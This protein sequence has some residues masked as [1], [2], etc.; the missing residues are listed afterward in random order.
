[1]S[2]DPRRV[3]AVFREAVQH[4]DTVG[5]API[6]GCERP[7]DVR[8]RRRVEAL[9]RA[10]D[11]HD[12]FLN[13]PM[14]SFEG[15]SSGG[16]AS[17]PIEIEALID[18]LTRDDEGEAARDR[19]GPP[20]A[21]PAMPETPWR[22][23]GNR[24]ED[25]PMAPDPRRVQAVFWETAQHPDPADRAPILERECSDDAELRRRVEALLRA[26]DAYDSFLNEP[27]V[28]LEAWALM[29]LAGPDDGRAEGTA[30]G[31]AANP[32]DSTT[33][34]GGPDGSATG[35]SRGDRLEQD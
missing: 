20:V 12:T 8:L 17:R 16:A 27:I 6:L 35:T 31:P 24:R 19:A 5:R 23:D 9:P 34:R 21:R 15:R 29:A 2:L 30:A 32:D 22:D 1:M 7:D 10:H 26:H 11:T 28:S 18:V 33:P 13:E 4:P 25:H 14:V 3:Q